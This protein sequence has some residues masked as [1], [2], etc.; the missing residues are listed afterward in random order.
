MTCPNCGAQ[1]EARRHV[2]VRCGARRVDG[3]EEHR[4]RS[5]PRAVA[6]SGGYFYPLDL[7]AALDPYDFREYLAASV[8]RALREPASARNRAALSAERAQERARRE[9]AL[10][11]AEALQR[12]PA[13]PRKWR[14]I[15]H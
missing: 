1:W 8:E 9:R 2:C 10:A 6:F 4:R 13:K 15:Q 7:Q 5:E 12:K 11:E 14:R 3:Q